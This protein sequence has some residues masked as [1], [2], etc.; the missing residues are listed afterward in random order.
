MTPCVEMLGTKT[1]SS[2]MDLHSLCVFTKNEKITNHQEKKL[3]LTLYPFI[4]CCVIHIVCFPF[5]RVPFCI[6]ISMWRKEI[7]LFW[8]THTHTHAQKKRTPEI[9]YGMYVYV[10]NHYCF[11]G[12]YGGSF[13]V[14][15]SATFLRGSGEDYF[16]FLCSQRHIY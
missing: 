9:I 8:W 4:P 13:F 11:T 7:E 10:L 5:V 2:R 15:N 1:I 3:N 14:L 16:F 6:Y 12:M